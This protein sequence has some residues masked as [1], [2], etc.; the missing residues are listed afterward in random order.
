MEISLI[1]SLDSLNPIL[2]QCVGTHFHFAGNLSC[3]QTDLAQDLENN[4][5]GL[6]SVICEVTT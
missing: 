1:N 5:L 2:D 4:F 6:S 3:L